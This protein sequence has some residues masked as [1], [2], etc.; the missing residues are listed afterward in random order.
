[1]ASDVTDVDT[2]SC[3]LGIEN[4]SNSPSSPPQTLGGD[5]DLEALMGVLFGL[6]EDER[7]GI[8]ADMSPK[9]RAAIL[10]LTEVNE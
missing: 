9:R 6:P 4:P 7:P 2:L 8:V 1:M 10:T 5:P 3:E